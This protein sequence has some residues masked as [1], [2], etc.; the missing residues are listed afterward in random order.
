MYPLWQTFAI[1]KQFILKIKMIILLLYLQYLESI[2]KLIYI[3]DIYYLLFRF[4]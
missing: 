4:V 3:L 2:I 1:R